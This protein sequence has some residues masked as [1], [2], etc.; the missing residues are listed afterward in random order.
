MRSGAVPWGSPNILP[1]ISQLGKLVNKEQIQIKGQIHSFIQKFIQHPLCGGLC[2]K[3][4]NQ[5]KVSK[6]LCCLG[7]HRLVNKWINGGLVRALTLQ[8]TDSSQWSRTEWPGPGPKAP[9]KA[10]LRVLSLVE[11]FLFLFLCLQKISNLVSL[12]VKHN[13]FSLSC[14]FQAGSISTTMLLGRWMYIL[15]L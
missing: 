5:R 13:F 7:A 6:S 9:T 14:V 8:G 12:G 3:I 10:K 1:C 4:G 15:V 2:A 11:N